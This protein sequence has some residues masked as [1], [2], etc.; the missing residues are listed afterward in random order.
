V[1]AYLDATKAKIAEYNDAGNDNL[2]V[3]ATYIIGKDGKIAF[4]HYDP[5][6]KKRFDIKEV[7]AM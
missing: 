7:I 1:P 2:P 6:Y 4:V 3:P 5:D